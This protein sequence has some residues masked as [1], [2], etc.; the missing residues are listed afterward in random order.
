MFMEDAPDGDVTPVGSPFAITAA[1]GIAVVATLVIGFAPGLVG[2]AGRARHVRARSVGRAVSAVVADANPIARGPIG[3]DEFMDVALYDPQVGFYMR[4]GGAGRRRDFLTSPEVGPLFGAV[5]ARR[6][7]RVV[8][9][10][11]AA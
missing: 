1:I 9:R 2:R 4:G 6:A 7:R 8:G 10:A 5:L 11:R 3:F